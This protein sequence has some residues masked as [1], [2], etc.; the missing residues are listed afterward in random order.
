MILAGGGG[1]SVWRVDGVAL[2]R[3]DYWTAVDRS[4]SEVGFRTG[5]EGP[6]VS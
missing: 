2:Y 5:P 1:G 3:G 6:E 4:Q